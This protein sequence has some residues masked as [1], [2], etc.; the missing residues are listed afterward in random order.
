M[1]KE[2][3]FSAYNDFKTGIF[4]KLSILLGIILLIIYAF[5]K[6][7]SV[8]IKGES[9]GWIQNIYNF[10]QSSRADSIIAF[11]VILLAVGVILYFFHYQFSK[12]AKI[13]EEI[14][15]G[16]EIEEYDLKK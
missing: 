15:N 9:A 6:I 14:E 3:H 5:L 1:I 12:L 16:K 11:S 7:S 8:F 10:S 13:A 4:Y 2:R